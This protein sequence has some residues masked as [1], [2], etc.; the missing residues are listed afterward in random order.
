MCAFTP[1]S[2]M[3]CQAQIEDALSL[4]T[5]VILDGSA[6]LFL[7]VLCFSEKHTFQFHFKALHFTGSPLIR[8]ARALELTS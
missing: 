5:A 1:Q 2:M 8:A 3:H 6:F 7:S 4:T